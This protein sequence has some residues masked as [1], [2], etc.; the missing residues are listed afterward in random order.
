MLR[1]AL[2][3]VRLRLYE[4]E[5]AAWALESG[6]SRRPRCIRPIRLV[7]LGKI[8]RASYIA[9]PRSCLAEFLQV[10]SYLS[11]GIFGENRWKSSIEIGVEQQSYR[12][13]GCDQPSTSLCVRSP[14]GHI[15]AP[16]GGKRKEKFATKVRPAN[17]ALLLYALL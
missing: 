3:C 7:S 15:D 4:P 5:V 8:E 6:L 16:W 11:P 13:R 10:W 17:P 2:R 9:P 14:A 12:E 1:K